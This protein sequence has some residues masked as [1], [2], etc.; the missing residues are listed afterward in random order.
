MSKQQQTKQQTHKQVDEIKVNMD[1]AGEKLKAK[2]DAKQKQSSQR[3]Q[4]K[5]NE[6]AILYSDE[7]QNT[8]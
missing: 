1:R 6:P 5:T 3:N 8:P 2:E 7:K 4:L